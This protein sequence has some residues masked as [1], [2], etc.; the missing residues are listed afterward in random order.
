MCC[1]TSLRERGLVIRCDRVMLS[2]ECYFALASI[3]GSLKLLMQFLS[4]FGRWAEYADAVILRQ[5]LS[6]NRLL[7]SQFYEML[8]LFWL[9][10]V[11]LMFVHVI[12]ARIT[13]LQCK[14]SPRFSPISKY[15][16]CWFHDSV[17]SALFGCFRGFVRPRP[18]ISRDTVILAFAHWIVM[19]SANAHAYLFVS[20]HWSDARPNFSQIH[21]R[22]NTSHVDSHGFAVYSAEWF[23]TP[24]VSGMILVTLSDGFSSRAKHKSREEHHVSAHFFSS[25]SGLRTVL[26]Q[27][28]A[29]FDHE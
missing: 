10:S 12:A 28:L 25:A 16:L 2:L 5:L 26:A 21:Q 11:G 17:A 19:C 7:L 29:C 18:S 24:T 14:F 8:S 23:S 15:N 3:M 13:M 22:S 6:M 9:S 27:F 1:A 4:D 20:S